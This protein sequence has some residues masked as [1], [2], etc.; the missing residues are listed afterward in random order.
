MAVSFH[1]QGRCRARAEEVFKLLWDP[2]RFPDWW[3]GMDR[4][5]DGPDGTVTR[6]MEQW[7]DFAYPTDVATHRNGAG[8]TISCLL[9]D[10]RHEWSL[11]PDPAGCIVAAHVELPDDEAG[12]L[13]GLRAETE[14]SLTRLIALAERDQDG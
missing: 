4:V 2:A 8:V 11:A 1:L 14:A 12:R 10:I 7:P 3:A 6:Y 13:D 9:S 5:E